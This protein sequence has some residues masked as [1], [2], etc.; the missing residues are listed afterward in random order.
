[1]NVLTATEPDRISIGTMEIVTGVDVSSG[2]DDAGK[3]VVLDAS[4]KID[5]T[6]L[7]P[8]GAGDMLK[9]TYDPNEDGV[10]DYA[11]LTGVAASTHTHTIANVT[12]L[13]TALDG[14]NTTISVSE[15]SAS[16][17]VT[18]TSANTYYAAPGA[19]LVLEAGT[20]ILIGKVT[21]GRTAT[22]AVRYTVR[23]RDTNNS[24]TLDESEI[25]MPS[26]NPHYATVSL[27][28]PFTALGSTTIQLQA[29]AN[30]ATS[31]VIKADINANGTGVNQA[32]RIMAIKIL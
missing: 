29:T 18:I 14:K 12:G 8:A 6:M 3:V 10:I 2:P 20:Y 31:C 27:F 23:I 30:Q 19:Q 11:Q 16:G 4:G 28:T 22:T 32:T 13:Q 17:D 1:M 26:V 21:V 24:L 25:Y 15:A 5:S 9:S 7:P